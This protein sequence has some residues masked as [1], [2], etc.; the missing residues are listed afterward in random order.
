MHHDRWVGVRGPPE[1]LELLEPLEPLELP[2]AQEVLGSGWLAPGTDPSRTPNRIFLRRL[3]V[4][5]E[6][7]TGES[8]PEKMGCSPR[9]TPRGYYTEA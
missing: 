4:G 8:T 7:A 3:P 6:L 5:V 2:A 9:A 1:L